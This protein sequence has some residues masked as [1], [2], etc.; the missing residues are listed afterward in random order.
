MKFH[1]VKLCTWQQ[2]ISVWMCGKILNVKTIP[3]KRQK[4]GIEKDEKEGPTL[5][6]LNQKICLPFCSI[7]EAVQDFDFKRNHKPD[8]FQ[9]Q[10]F[11][12]N[13]PTKPFRFI[14][15]VFKTKII[16]AVKAIQ[17]GF[18]SLHFYYYNIR[19]RRS[20]ANGFY[21]PDG[22]W[23][24][25]LGVCRFFIRSSNHLTNTAEHS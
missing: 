12:L 23:F 5:Q 20:G 6:W 9:Q 3:I 19:C 7:L 10:P 17:P 25:Y 15:S 13:H 16:S 8:R 18:G 2:I 1:K 14:S 21:A 11:I 24:H 22:N 4:S